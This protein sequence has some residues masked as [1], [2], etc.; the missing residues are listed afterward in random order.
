MPIT[1]LDEEDQVYRTKEE[2]YSAVINEIKKSNEK[3]QPYWLAQH[4]S[5]NQKKFQNCLKERI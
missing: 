4:Q 3:G 1:R 2:K 5:I